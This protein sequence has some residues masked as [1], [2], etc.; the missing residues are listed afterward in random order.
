MRSAAT[1]EVEVSRQTQSRTPCHIE[2][3]LDY[4]PIKDVG[5]PLD[6]TGSKN[7]QFERSRELLILRYNKTNIVAR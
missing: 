1:K 6:V 4:V 7:R 2:E 5:T 3:H